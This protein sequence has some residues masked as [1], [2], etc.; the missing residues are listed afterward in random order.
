MSHVQPGS[1]RSVLSD[2]DIPFGR[3]IVIFVK[4]GLAAVPAA[5]I[6]MVIFSL[7]GA[8]FAAILGPGFFHMIGPL[9]PGDDM[10]L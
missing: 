3:L 10:A 5:I 4:L 9:G 6:L 8:A 7:I 1:Q 2:I